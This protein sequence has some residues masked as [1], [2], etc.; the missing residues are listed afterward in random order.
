MYMYSDEQVFWYFSVDSHEKLFLKSKNFQNLKK[1][2]NEELETNLIKKKIIK[3]IK[4]N[5]RM[6]KYNFFCHLKC[7]FHEIAHTIKCQLW[8]E[9]GNA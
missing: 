5:F 8:H 1:K 7:Y 2:I 6:R 4:M 3:L 9:W